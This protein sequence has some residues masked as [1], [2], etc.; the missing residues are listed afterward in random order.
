MN[1]S[2]PSKQ[3]LPRNQILIG[4]ATERLRQLPDGQ[5]DSIV[6]SPP[7]FRLR[8][9]GVDGQ[10]GL[11]AHVDEWAQALRPI[12]HEAARVLMPTGTLWLNLGDTYST[13]GKQGAPGRKSLLMA[14]ERVALM[15]LGDGWLLRNK[16]VWAKTNHAPSSAT[17]RLTCSWEVIYLLVRSPRYFFDLDAIRVPHRSRTTAPPTRRRAASRPPRDG[18]TPRPW[19]GP[20]TDRTASGL[21]A[22]KEAGLPGHPLGKNPGDVW[23]LSV[24]NYR[25]AH[26]ATFPRHL[27]EQ[28]I[29][30][31]TPERR[32]AICRSPWRRPVERLGAVATRLALSPTCGCP[33]NLTSSELG[34]VLDPFMG[35]GTTAIA[36]ESLNRDW[37]GIELNPEF[38]DQANE[39]IATAR[40]QPRG[41]L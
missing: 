35:A 16:I 38:A 27:A 36:A 28:M 10:L 12:L 8:D 26:F 19:R 11:E 9:Y 40:G 33:D 3:P 37:L 15:L 32:C 25:G 7:F 18:R 2:A 41:S 21:A 30:A 20:N 14:P 24:S 39:R 31:G 6:T 17:D 23:R 22:L 5:V 1:R 13:S 29:R 4:D 34:L